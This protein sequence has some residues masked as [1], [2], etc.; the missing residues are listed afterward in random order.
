MTQEAESEPQEE[1]VVPEPEAELIF[2]CPC[3]YC[4]DDS[5]IP[6]KVGFRAP[7]FSLTVVQPTQIIERVELAD[8][9]DKWLILATFPNLSSTI[10]PSEMAAFSEQINRFADI[11]C[12]ILGLTL[13]NV[14]S[15][16]AWVEQPRNEGGIGPINFPVGADLGL[17][18]ERRYGIIDDDCIPS[19][20][21]VI[22]DP[23]QIVRH[24]SIGL[25]S[26]ARSVE[27]I[28]R[29]VKAFQFVREHGEVCPAQWKEGDP[30]ITPNV[31]DSKAYFEK[32]Y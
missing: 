19:R 17:D 3:H 12:E 27:E 24:I 16:T 31:V 18:V 23:D 10:T 11:N 32:N 4:D 14:Y 8:F 5:I 15:L 9:K 25:D 21:V 7:N 28:L 30:A 26:V 1:E 29:L 13:E 20:S 2:D 22:V 6:A